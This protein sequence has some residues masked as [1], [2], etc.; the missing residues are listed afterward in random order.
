[1][2]ISLAN[3]ADG[4]IPPPE[5]HRL[6]GYTTW[7]A[8]T[9]DLEVQAEPRIVES[10]VSP[11][12]IVCGQPRRPWTPAPGPA[13]RTVLAARPV[14]YWRLEEMS[15]PLA[16]DS[17]E[18][19]RTAVYEPPVAFFLDGSAPPAFAAPGSIN[20]AAHFAGGRLR[21]RLPHI[22]GRY[23]VAMWAG[24]GMPADWRGVAGRMFSRGPDGGLGAHGDHLG[25][26]GTNS[27]PGRLVFV[28]GE[29][30]SS[31]VA[32]RSILPRWQWRHVLLVRDGPAV[33]VDLDGRLEIEGATGTPGGGDFFFGERADGEDGWE[34]RLDEIAVFDRPLSPDE[35]AALAAP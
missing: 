17:G 1:M 5:Q 15:G 24:N 6:G 11:L 9:A 8:G 32:G 14:T 4:Y 33:R 3:G 27:A 35:A 28:H 30:P 18:H 13:A 25:V 12:E 34:G 10:I 21:A 20:R 29:D 2:V 23:S 19:G 26:A 31:V 16:N 7:P 22:G